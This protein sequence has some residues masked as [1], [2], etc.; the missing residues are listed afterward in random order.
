MCHRSERCLSH[1]TSRNLWQ[2]LFLSLL[3]CPSGSVPVI[4]MCS[5]PPNPAPCPCCR[6]IPRAAAACPEGRVLLFSSQKLILFSPCSPPPCTGQAGGTPQLLMRCYDDCCSY[7]VIFSAQRYFSWSVFAKVPGAA[8]KPS[9][10]SVYVVP[11][12]RLVSV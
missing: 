8:L 10:D 6:L 9:A 12:V 5:L 2:G 7:S 1:L 11:C 3:R 4:A